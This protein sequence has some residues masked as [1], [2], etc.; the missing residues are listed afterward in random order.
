VP[1]AD[2]KHPQNGNLEYGEA[3][4]QAPE[5]QAYRDITQV[6]KHETDL[7]LCEIRLRNTDAYTIRTDDREKFVQAALLPECPPATLIL[8]FTIMRGTGRPHPYRSRL[9]HLDSSLAEV[10]GDARAGAE[11]QGGDD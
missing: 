8:T 9:S 1:V 5:V 3:G 10:G 6:F 2:P 7:I 4:E 11:I